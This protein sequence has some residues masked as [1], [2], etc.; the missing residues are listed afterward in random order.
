M[1][2]EAPKPMKPD[3]CKNL[4][5]FSSFRWLRQAGLVL[6]TAI[7]SC[8]LT[9][10]ARAQ[11]FII[12]S[13]WFVTTNSVANTDPSTGLHIAAGD[14]NRGLAYNALSN[15]ILVCNKGVNGSG[16]MASIDV[17]DAVTGAYAGTAATNGI[18]GGTFLLDQVVAADDGVIYSANLSTAVGST[19]FKIYQ[20]TN[21]QTPSHIAFSGDPSGGTFTSR[22]MGDNLVAQGSGTNTVLLAP[23]TSSTTATTNVVLFST[24]DG[25]AFTP[26][27]LNIVNIPVPTSGN[28]G[29][30]IAVSFYT[31]NTFLFKQNGAPLYLVQYPANFASMS[32]PV[33]ATAIDTN[34][35]FSTA[36]NTGQTVLNYSAAGSLLATLGPIPNATP[37]TTPIN[38][39]F[40]KPFSAVS[41]SAG[42]TNSVHFNGNGNFVGGVALG[43]A[44]K[45]NLL[46]TLDCNNGVRGWGLTFVAAPVAPVINTAPLGGSVYTNI[47]SFTFNVSAA[48][49]S[50]LFYQWQFNT[51]SNLATASDIPLATNSTFTISP[52]TVSTSGWYDVI[53]S[54]VAGVTSSVPVLLTVSAPL[55]SPYVTSLWSLPADNSQPYLDT[56]YNTRGLAFDPKTMSVLLAEHSAAQIYALDATNNGQLKF[57]M[58][59]PQTGLPAGSIFP[60]GQVGVADDGVV[61]CCNV[62]S[63]QPG[64]QTGGVDF[65]ITRFDSVVTATNGDGS[66]N[67]SN[68]FEAAWTGDP[69]NFL[70]P[71]S[72][73]TY[74]GG[75]R[76][77]DSMAVR[78]AG[79]NTQILLGTYEL[80]GAN[81]FGTGPGT[82]VAILTT[83]DGINFTPTTI[84]VAGVPSGFS[85]LGVAWGASNTFWTKSPGFD[86]RQIQYDLATGTGTVLLEFSSTASSG[87][88]NLVCGIGLDVANNILAGVNV[89][90]TPNDLELFQ[91]PSLGFPP[92]PYFQEFFP[93]NNPNI[94]GNAATTVK[95]PYIF[96]LDANNGIIGLKYSVPLLPFNILA[97]KANNQQILTWQTV[98]GHTYQLQA[99]NALGGGAWPNVG[100]P[101]TA[102]TSGTQSY[103]N[104]LGGSAMFYR[105]VAQ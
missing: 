37:S 95:F 80:I 74:S 68:I 9:D 12:S 56:S 58:T 59:T 96:S 23:M 64:Q 22:R 11:H 65:S 15:Q 45:T 101:V 47:G 81:Q 99:T 78:G 51:V 2:N 60:L 18:S 102:A 86:L 57:M 97:T 105:V 91:I 5:I 35:N 94:N 19:A 13:N 10:H 7:V 72:G 63:Y 98:I 85:Y 70:V 43:G 16:T 44:G 93:T 30:A 49:T 77:G 36:G 27:V 79:T 52:L 8:G 90:D 104:T 67:S 29:P 41:T 87:S 34:A 17:L 62:S 42:S 54:N 46:F 31:N 76:W 39:S 66:L 1:F 26:T 40:G 21:W 53:I 100:P 4:D 32:S 103:T 71:A 33:T 24:T 38:V 48:G 73:A 14:V 88:L 25:I 84:A 3:S 89:G 61:Y 6:L 83:T 92:E 75:D 28:N 82:N 69:G 55:T 50:P 20:W